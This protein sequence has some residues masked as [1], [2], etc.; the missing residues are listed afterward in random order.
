M[1][2]Q[3]ATPTQTATSAA[4]PGASNAPTATADDDRLIIRGLRVAP[5]AKP[6]HEILQGIDLEI[7]K[8]ELHAIMGPNGSV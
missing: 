7:G 2:D 4:A 5:L 6:D 8:G 3:T 1:T